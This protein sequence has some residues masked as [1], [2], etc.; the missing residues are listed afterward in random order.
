MNLFLYLKPEGVHTNSGCL[1]VNTSKHKSQTDHKLDIS[2]Q[3]YAA[4]KQLTNYLST[5]TIFHRIKCINLWKETYMK[6]CCCYGI[7][8]SK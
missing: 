7:Y 6:Q 5:A 4:R 1:K 2:G 3:S 8:S